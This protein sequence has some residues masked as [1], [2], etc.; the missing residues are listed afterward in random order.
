MA[1]NITIYGGVKSQTFKASAEIPFVGAV[2]TI[3]PLAY[4]GD[5]TGYSI[6]S[7]KDSSLGY[8]VGAAF[9]KPEIAMLQVLKPKDLQQLSQHHQSFQR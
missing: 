1:D 3:S 9:E 5:G 6:S 7:T 8:V 2:K 4:Y